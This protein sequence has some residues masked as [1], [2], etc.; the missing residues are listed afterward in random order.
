LVLLFQSVTTSEDEAFAMKQPGMLSPENLHLSALSAVIPEHATVLMYAIDGSNGV[1]SFHKTQAL[2]DAAIFLP[3]RGITID[4]TFF[5][6]LFDRSDEQ[7]IDS[8]LVLNYDYILHYNDP[9]IRDPAI[10]SNYH[11]VWH[12]APDHLVLYQRNT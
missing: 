12:F 11:A 1:S 3:G 7:L 8:H 5:G 2:A 9:T 10:P 6:G 4:G